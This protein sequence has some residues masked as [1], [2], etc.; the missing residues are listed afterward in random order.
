MNFED[1]PIAFTDLGTTGLEKFRKQDP[2]IRHLTSWHEIFEIGLVL[3]NQKTLEVIDTWNTKVKIQYPHRMT[4]QARDFNGY[5]DEDWRDA[6]DLETALEEYAKRTKE[7]IFAA[8]NSIFDCWGFLE[9]AFTANCVEHKLDFRRI[10]V[11]NRS[12]A[13][14][15][16]KGYRLD[17]YRLDDVAEFLKL[18]REPLPRRAING[19][20]KACEV[21]KALQYQNEPVHRCFP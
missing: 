6:V 15:E 10:C 9:A 16:A 7:A 11:W 2:A 3:A 13:T 12:Q 1:R 21:Y 19:A 20:M 18:G 14:L 5:N 8:H 4:P 17:S